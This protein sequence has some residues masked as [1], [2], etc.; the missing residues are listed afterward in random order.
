VIDFLPEQRGN[1]QMGGTMRL[2]AYRCVVSPGT[3]GHAAYGCEEVWERHRHRYEVNPDSIADLKA[4]GLVMSG[5]SP[6][7]RLV[8]MVELPGHPWFLAVQ[9]HPEFGSK[10]LRPHPLFASF[11]RACLARREAQSKR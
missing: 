6:D 2:G 8:E 11:V 10:P 5:M 1:R 3:L 9:S 4:G 7:G